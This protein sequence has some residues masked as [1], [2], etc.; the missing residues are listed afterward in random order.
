MFLYKFDYWKISTHPLNLTKHLLNHH[1]LFLVQKLILSH[2]SFAQH[3]YKFLF[4]SAWGWDD[5][6]IPI[7]R[8][9]TV[10]H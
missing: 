3:Y 7:A 8:V 4:F 9:F 2:T 5:D 6:G 10:S 1:L